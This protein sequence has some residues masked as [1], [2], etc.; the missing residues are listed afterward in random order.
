LEVAENKESR[1]QILA[2]SLTLGI[3]QHLSIPSA[4]LNMLRSLIL[5]AMMAVAVAAQV[6]SQS[7]QNKNEMMRS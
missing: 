4:F 3:L 5:V 2:L 7:R 6:P 1:P